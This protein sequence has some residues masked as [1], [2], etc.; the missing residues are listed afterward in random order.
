MNYNFYTNM[1]HKNK[2]IFFLIVFIFLFGFFS[3]K[4]ANACANGNDCAYLNNCNVTGSVD[5]SCDTGWQIY[6]TTGEAGCITFEFCYGNMTILG[7]SYV[8]QCLPTDGNNYANGSYCSTNATLQSCYTSPV[9]CGSSGCGYLTNASCGGGGG[10]GGTNAACQTPPNGGTYSTAPTG[11]LCSSGTATAVSGSGP[12]TWSCNS[13]DGGTNASCSANYGAGIDNSQCVSMTGVPVSVAPGST[14]NA[15]VTMKN[16]GT[17]TWHDASVAPTTQ[18]YG[19]LDLPWPSP[20]WGA[21]WDVLPAHTIAPGVTATFNVFGTAPATLGSYNFDWQMLH[22]GV[23][24]FGDI[25]HQVVIVV[26]TAPTASLTV[27]TTFGSATNGTSVYTYAGND[28]PT[29]TWTSTNTTSCTVTSNNGDNKSGLN[30][31]NVTAN[32]LGNDSGSGKTWTYTLICVGAGGNV[33]KTASVIIPPAPTNVTAV[34]PAPG[35]SASFTWTAP[36]GYTNF[37]V[38]NDD[39]TAGGH[40]YWNENYAGTSYA[41]PNNF[42]G[43]EYPVNPIVNHTYSMWIH[44]RTPNG[45]WSASSGVVYPCL[46]PASPTASLTVNT[47]FGSASNGG[48]VYN[49]NNQP[50]TLTWTST[51]TT[52]CT[53]TSNN[54]DNQSGLTG[55][56]VAANALG[57][58]SGSGK[59]WT[60]TLNCTGASGNVSQTASV[61]IPPAPTNVTAV[62]PA[63]GTAATF[64]WTAPVG[65]TDFY[66]RNIDNASPAVK[67]YANDDYVGTTYTVPNAYAGSYTLV[68]PIVNHNY[69]MW[70]D[71]RAPNGAY[72]VQSLVTYTCQ[73]PGALSGTLTPAVSSCII[74]S[75]ASTCNINYSWTTTNPVGTSAVTSSYPVANTTVANGNNGGPT[76]FAIPWGGRTFYLYNNAV[77]L[78]T[79]TV[80]ASSVTCVAGTGWDGSK[81]ATSIDGGWSAWSTCSVSCGGGT[82]TRGCTNPA[83][84]YGGAVCSGATSQACNPQVCVGT[85]ISANPTTITAG[86]STTLTWSGTNSCTGTNF[87]T[88]AG[89]P[90][91]GSLSVSPTTTTTYTVTCNGTSSSVTVTVRKK[92]TIIE[93]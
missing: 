58:D 48:S 79:S 43:F 68:N 37:Y 11:T 77:Q 80:A 42:T 21:L 41:V 17:S 72:S 66:V 75:G 23:A 93:N 86:N 88:G 28:T 59:T 15:V 85:N 64:N 53:V 12:W 29:L 49:G 47:A 27:N 33:S 52:S 56:N 6:Q 18:P 5:R 87:S 57:N 3:I 4:S 1:Y 62:C 65:Y 26:A 19:L 34:C 36:V 13:T 30:G 39:T 35:T 22:N 76:P 63:P 16:V 73:S 44:T 31:T 67:V 60:Y 14:I 50:V 7:T 69:N 70:V 74:A 45:A 25:C 55:T 40:V 91:T 78:A 8:G 10:G 51:N 61:I 54:S 81:C 38:R 46:S 20:P 2:Y 90:A 32:A 83:P 24:W 92:P 89:N 82:Q 9:Y 71:S 84:A